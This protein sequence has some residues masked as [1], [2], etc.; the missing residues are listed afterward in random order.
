MINSHAKELDWLLDNLVTRL[1]GVEG[2]VVLSADGLLIGRSQN[3]TREGAE[4]LS[5]MS[6]ALQSLAIGVGRHFAKGTVRQTIVELERAFL[7]VTAA[8]KGACLALLAE[9]N[10]E[11]ELIVYEM[12]VMVHQ[13]GASLTATPRRHIDQPRFDPPR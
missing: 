8:G 13:V 10:A 4:Q 7:I 5:A 6:S 12:N 3:V 2:A 9:E 1:A 11:I